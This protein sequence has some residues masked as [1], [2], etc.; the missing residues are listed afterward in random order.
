MLRQLVSIFRRIRAAGRGVRKRKDRSLRL[1]ETLPLGERKY[2]ALVQVEGERFLVGAAGNSI[3]LL[4]RLAP[5]T[6]GEDA[7]AG[8]GSGEM[9][10]PEE[11]E[12]WR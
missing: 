6:G 3:S 9:Y 12:A 10:V 1:C 5:T 4:A 2:L 7:F 8:L 11:Y